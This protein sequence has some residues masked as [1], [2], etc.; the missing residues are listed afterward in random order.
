MSYSGSVVLKEQLFQW[1]LQI[2][3]FFFF[4]LCPLWRGP[5]PLLVWFKIP[6][7]QGWFVSSLI[8]TG[9]LV[10]ANRF[11]SLDITKR[12]WFS[13]RWPL[14]IPGDH[15]LVKPIFLRSDVG[16]K[17]EHCTVL[18]SKADLRILNNHFLDDNRQ[19]KYHQ[20]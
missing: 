14:P 10:L 16:L 2:F 6:F 19:L 3:T 12:L 9:L 5:G 8:E 20:K 7:T 17:R 1:L 18:I 4:K 13:L 11:F 15:D